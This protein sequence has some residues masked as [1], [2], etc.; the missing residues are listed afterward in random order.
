MTFVAAVHRCGRRD[1]ETRFRR[2]ASAGCFRSLS[3]QNVEWMIRQ[4]LC[5]SALACPTE[6][7][8]ELRVTLGFASCWLVKFHFSRSIEELEN[9]AQS[10][11]FWRSLVVA[12]EPEDTLELQ[13][14]KKARKTRSSGTTTFDLDASQWLEGASQ[15]KLVLSRGGRTVF[16]IQAMHGES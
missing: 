8:R 16:L 5:I 12:I 15:Q 6:F 10:R 13:R 3:G 9:M 7:L 1:V 11:R 4:S 14:R 2:R